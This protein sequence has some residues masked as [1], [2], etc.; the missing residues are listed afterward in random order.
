[1]KRETINSNH[2][3]SLLIQPRTSPRGGRPQAGREGVGFGLLFGGM[4]MLRILEEAFKGELR[5]E[6][7]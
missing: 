2:E 6:K 3:T 7:K 4:L 1:M 5:E